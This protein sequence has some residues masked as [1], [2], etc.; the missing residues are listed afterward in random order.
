MKPH[1]M[2]TVTSLLTMLLFTFHWADDMVR[3]FAPG[4]LSGLGGVLIMIVWLCGTLLLAER[5]WGQII[6]LLGSL[7]ALGVL[8]L[9]MTGNGLVG[10]RIA[11]S[12][13]MLF[14]VWTLITL[15]ISGSFGAILSV[16]AL[17]HSWRHQGSR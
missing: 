14:W 12:S 3:G 11:N 13:G 17:W 7:L 9:H 4:N 8:A 2:L 5:R 16:R 15:G 6:M 1:L 10:G